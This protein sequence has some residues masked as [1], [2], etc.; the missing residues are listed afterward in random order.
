MSRRSGSRSPVGTLEGDACF[1]ASAAS[2]AASR[3]AARERSLLEVFDGVFKDCASGTHNLACV[4]RALAAEGPGE[5]LEECDRRLGPQ[6][7]LS[8]AV[9]HYAQARLDEL[10]TSA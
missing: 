5:Y 3:S 6:P 10:T 9:C 7:T 2:S 8:G 1:E 4:A